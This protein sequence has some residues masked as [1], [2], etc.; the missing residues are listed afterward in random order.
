[1]ELTGA[2]RRHL[3]AFTRLSQEDY[4]L[5]DALAG[6]NLRQAPARRDMIREG[7]RPRGVIAILDGW[8]CA[9]KQLPDG[10]RQIVSFL[11]PGDLGDSNVFIL[12]RMD[13]SI[14]AITD[15]SYAEIPPA[16]FEAA[17]ARSP[18][19]ARA[20][21]WHELVTASIHREW[22]ANVGQRTAYERIAHLLCEMFVKLDAVG[23]A[24]GGSCPWPLT[25]ADVADATGLT[26][27]HVNRTLQELRRSGLIALQARRLSIPDFAALA[28]AGGFSR[29]YLH[30]D[31]EAA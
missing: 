30:L 25:Q 7:E 8:A 22:T 31:R 23:L 26:S 24:E 10:R 15:L 12:D 27:V 5:I 19:L 6:S 13:H 14:G 1:V 17:T 21:W 18:Q 4:A 2:L 16:E 29:A 9:Y 11:V 20:V 3:G 28:D